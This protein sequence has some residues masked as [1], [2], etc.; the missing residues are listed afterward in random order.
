[1]W[2]FIDLCG[3]PLPEK[4]D[5]IIDVIDGDKL[6][7]LLC[8]HF[9]VQYPG[10]SMMDIEEGERWS[11]ISK[12][13]DHV[14][15]DHFKEVERNPYIKVALANIEHDTVVSGI[16]DIESGKDFTFN[17]NQRVMKGDQMRTTLGEINA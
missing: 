5:V 9:K 10:K 17:R 12:I 13:K 14:K 7:Y 8:Q 2:Q 11:V 6:H 16:R 15:S 4:V 3:K 1:M